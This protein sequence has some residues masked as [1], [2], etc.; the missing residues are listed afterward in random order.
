MT[1]GGARPSAAAE[2]LAPTVV[3]SKL[4]KVIVEVLSDSTE[5]YDR[6]TK[7]TLYRQIPSLQELILISQNEAYVGCFVRQDSGGWLLHEV[8]DLTGT[9]EFSS[10]HISI[11]LSEIYR[12]VTFPQ[13]RLQ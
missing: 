7:S 12:G 9:I 6:G 10:M 3:S 2:T 1:E 11:A 13:Q 5:K 8:L 4:A